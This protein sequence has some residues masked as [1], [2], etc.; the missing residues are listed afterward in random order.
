MN[1]LEFKVVNLNKSIIYNKV[2][3]IYMPSTETFYKN[4]YIG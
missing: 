2:Q 3:S 1:K 4:T